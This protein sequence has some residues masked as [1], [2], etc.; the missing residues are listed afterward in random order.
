[1]FFAIEICGQY[2]YE[3]NLSKNGVLCCSLNYIHRFFCHG[4]MVN[5]CADSR[6]RGMGGRGLN[7]ELLNRLYGKHGV[8]IMSQNLSWSALVYINQ[9]VLFDGVTAAK[10]LSGLTDRLNLG[11]IGSGLIKVTG[12]TLMCI[13]CRKGQFHIRNTPLGLLPFHSYF[14]CQ[15]KCLQKNVTEKK[16]NETQNR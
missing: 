8:Q 4:Y 15:T 6:N 11:T 13:C 16:E 3:W 9:T 1:M 14:H 12:G 2:Y 7:F 5:G 10:W